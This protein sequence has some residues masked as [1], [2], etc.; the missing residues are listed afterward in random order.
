MNCSM[1]QNGIRFIEAK[2]GITKLHKGDLLVQLKSERNRMNALNIELVK[3]SDRYK[4]KVQKLLNEVINDRDSFNFYMIQSMKRF[5]SFSNVFFFYDS[6]YVDLKKSAFA[7]NKFLDDKLNRTVERSSDTMDYFIL[8]QDLTKGQSLESWIL[9][10]K[11][12][13][14][15]PSPFPSKVRINTLTT[16]MNTI[17]NKKQKFQLNSNRYASSLQKKYESFYKRCNK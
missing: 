5:Y 6:D 10:N 16:Y 7:G 4:R 3:G 13:V 12:N 14:E 8:K 11:D 15:M 1:A 17:F 2:V 9:M